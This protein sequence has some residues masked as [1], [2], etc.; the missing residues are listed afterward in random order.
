M[1]RAI[2]PLTCDGCSQP[3][4]ERLPGGVTEPS[5]PSGSIDTSIYKG[6]KEQEHGRS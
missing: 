1:L 5:A 2:L 4:G 6:E 3:G